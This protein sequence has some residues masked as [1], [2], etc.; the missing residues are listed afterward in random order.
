MS[1]YVPN[2]PKGYR[3]SGVEPVDIHAQRWAEYK[4]FPPKEEAKPN[5]LGCVFAKSCDLPDGVIDHKKPAGFIPVEKVSN[6]GEF[7]ILGGNEMDADGN[8]P[9]K[10]ISGST[11]P[12]ALGSLLFG[13]A[14][15]AAGASCGGLCTAG[16]TVATETALTGAGAGAG[17]GTAVVATGVVL[18]SLLGVVGMLLPG[19]LGDSSLYTEDQ[20]KALKEGR[21]RVRI[22]VEQ[23]ADGT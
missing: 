19:N 7:A 17:S 13:K 10:K 2:P 22:H 14:A 23:Q 4:E 20:L 11:L 1:G 3:N 12:I 15:A 5:S 9:L 8:I 21:T 16:A 18:G 6:Y